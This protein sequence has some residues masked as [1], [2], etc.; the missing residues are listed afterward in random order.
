MGILLTNKNI[1]NSKKEI[2][3]FTLYEK[4]LLNKRVNVEHA[5]NK[6]KQVKR[7]QLRYDKYI[8]TYNFFVFLSSL[9]ILI[10]KTNIYLN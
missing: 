7:C 6:Y 3:K 10:N 9:R 8:K 4:L 2:T 1:I 5:I